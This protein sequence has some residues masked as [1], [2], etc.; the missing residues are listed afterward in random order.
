MSSKTE[1]DSRLL[2][3]L[4]EIKHEGDQASQRP[5]RSNALPSKTHG[6]IEIQRTELRSIRTSADPD[7]APEKYRDSGSDVDDPY[8]ATANYMASAFTDRSPESNENAHEEVEG[9]PERRR[10]RPR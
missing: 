10:P 8:V 1:A 5:H 4:A 7:E 3:S 6:D 2:E 9:K